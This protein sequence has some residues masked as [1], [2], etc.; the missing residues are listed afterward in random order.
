M[1]PREAKIEALTRCINLIS[2]DVVSMPI[3]EE[4]DPVA[5]AVYA[6]LAELRTRLR[7]FYAPHYECPVHGRM[8]VDELRFHGSNQD[9]ATCQ[10]PVDG[11]ECGR[12]CEW[13]AGPPA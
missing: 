10:E 9:Q 6:I 4:S 7:M 2:N 1:K 8:E 11:E 3:T 5:V 12:A 13:I